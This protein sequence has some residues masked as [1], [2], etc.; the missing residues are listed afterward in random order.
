MNH[1]EVMARLKKRAEEYNN[2]IN[3]GSGAVIGAELPVRLCTMAEKISEEYPEFIEL[4]P[5]NERSEG[6][7]RRVRHIQKTGECCGY[8]MSE[9]QLHELFALAGRKSIKDPVLYL[10]RVIDRL[11]VE[12]T[13]E[14]LSRRLR[15]DNCV[16]V[17]AAK[18]QV[19]SEWTVKYWRDLL[20]GRYSM[21][22]LMLAVEIAEGKERPAAYFTACFRG[23]KPKWLCE[24]AE[25][26]C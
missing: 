13:L 24:P 16:Q 15:P 11:H 1:K 14:T 21:N 9:E 5:P 12:R 10:C 8:K 3:R 25:V 6:L 20:A 4:C 17:V 22:D 26:V 19:Q 7:Y 23:G 18:L 2:K